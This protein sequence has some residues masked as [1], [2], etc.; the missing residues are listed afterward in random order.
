MKHLKK[1]EDLS[2]LDLLAQEN[3]L[4]KNREDLHRQGLETASKSKQGQHLPKLASD[5]IAREVSNAKVEDRKQIVDRVIDGLVK[6]GNN[7]PGYQSFKEE[8]LAFLDEFP[9]E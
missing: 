4:R 3:E 8:L 1:F 5:K 6:D 9:K 2:H 7:N